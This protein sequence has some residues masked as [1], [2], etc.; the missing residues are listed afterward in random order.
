LTEI[1][2]LKMNYDPEQQRK[3]LA[4]SPVGVEVREVASVA[5]GAGG[6]V[7]IETIPGAIIRALPFALVVATGP[8]GGSDVEACDWFV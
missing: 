8:W 1:G 5:G 7:R 6:N 4:A 3:A 2:S